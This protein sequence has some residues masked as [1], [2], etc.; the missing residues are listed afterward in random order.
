MSSVVKIKELLSP[1][2]KRPANEVISVFKL[3]LVNPARSAI[4]ERFVFH[5]PKIEDMASLKNNDLAT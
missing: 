4:G 1:E 2:R 5:Y 3:Y